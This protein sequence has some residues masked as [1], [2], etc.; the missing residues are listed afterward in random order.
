MG[1][2]NRLGECQCEVNKEK[3]NWGTGWA[4]A[5]ED[6]KSSAEEAMSAG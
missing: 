4:K 2:K 5:M 1:W 3:E 6:A